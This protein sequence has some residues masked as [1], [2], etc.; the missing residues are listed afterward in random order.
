MAEA[1]LKTAEEQLTCPICFDLFEEPKALPCLHTFCRKCIADH[2]DRHA[3]TDG[4]PYGFRC[5]TCRRFVT[6]P[7]GLERNPR[8]WTK[9]LEG[10]HVIVSLL[11]AY[12]TPRAG[13]GANCCMMHPDRELEFYC[14]DHSEFICSVCALEHRKC[15][16]VQTREN[17]EEMMNLSDD[18]YHANFDERERLLSLTFEQCNEAEK[19]ISDRKSKLL[20]LDKSET[21]ALQEVQTLRMRINATLE[22][23][24][25]KIKS[26]LTKRKAKEISKIEMEIKKCEKIADRAKSSLELLQTIKPGEKSS[27]FNTV[28]KNHESCK[29]KIDS[30]RKKNLCSDMKFQ[31]SNVV[32]TFVQNFES[33]GSIQIIDCNESANDKITENNLNEE[34]KSIIALK[35]CDNT[36]A[37]SCD[38]VVQQNTRPRPVPRRR[39]LSAISTSCSRDQREVVCIRDAG[40][41]KINQA[42]PKQSWITGIVTL[43]NDDL[44]LV[45]YHN[46]RVLL[47][48]SDFNH[49]STVRVSPPAYDATVVDD[50]VLLTRPDS[51]DGVIMCVV[52]DGFLRIQDTVKIGKQG[53]SLCYKGGLLA[54]CSSN[55]LEVHEKD[56]DYW[57][58]KGHTLL[59]RTKLTYVAIDNQSNQVYVTNQQYPD[60]E[61]LCLSVS[62]QILW[63][64]SHQNL[65][66]PTGV[67]F[68]GNNVFVAS[69]DKSRIIQLTK[70]GV[71]VESVIDKNIKYPWK[72]NINNNKII[73]S[74]HKSTLESDIKKTLVCFKIDI[75]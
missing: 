12:K 47:Y 6:A 53:R 22:R 4:Y 32:D 21:L 30:A 65:N 50:G 49:L 57:I 15:D 58:S 9:Y 71:Y 54:I 64:F 42:L 45:D 63:R 2:V 26:K 8:D 75:Q 29:K 72:L 36:T 1:I 35:S 14:F 7:P 56:S 34:N 16:D 41:L 46:E 13:H 51:K 66:F 40:Y 69:W 55:V 38:N 43:A 33:I 10:N 74:Q 67:A 28:R 5:P 62:G 37:A 25:D 11:D 39:P 19:L 44:L 60:P 31:V 59:D 48:D 17:A 27:E 23:E 61:L 70:D 3:H 24:E 68:A 20:E 18:K 52:N 73:V